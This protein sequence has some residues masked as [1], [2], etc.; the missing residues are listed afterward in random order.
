MPFVSCIYSRKHVIHT[1]P[2]LPFK[3]AARTP[4]LPPLFPR[5]LA[6]R[7]MRPDI[8][9]L[10]LRRHRQWS[11]NRICRLFLFPS[12][13]PT[14]HALSPPHIR[15]CAYQLLLVTALQ[16]IPIDARHLVLVPHPQPTRSWLKATRFAVSH[17]MDG[18][19]EKRDRGREGEKSTC[20]RANGVAAG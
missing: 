14:L 19:D 12:R 4:F 15:T 1:E 18:L 2:S 3:A 13:N 9:R 8:R 20:A 5:H 17:V 11:A 7:P 10:H 6:P 16:P